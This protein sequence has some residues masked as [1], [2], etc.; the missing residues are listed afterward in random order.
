MAIK[1]S[2]RTILDQ[3]DEFLCG[4]DG[5]ELADILSALRGPDHNYDCG[6]SLLKERTTT[7]I[8][9]AA[10]PLLKAKNESRR[11]YNIDWSFQQEKSLVIDNYIHHHFLGHIR[12]ARE[13]LGMNPT[14]GELLTNTDP[15][16]K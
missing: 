16:N 15:D 2:V 14:T 10:F 5:L 13:A 12:M 7:H 6:T 3:I 1:P 4:P 11:K 8:R 9:A